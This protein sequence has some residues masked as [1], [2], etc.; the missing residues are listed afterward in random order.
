[1][2]P[3]R[4][5]VCLSCLRLCRHHTVC[6][7][8]LVRCQCNTNSKFLKLMHKEEIFTGDDKTCILAVVLIRIF[9]IIH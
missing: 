2:L 3:P 7:C 5:K 8:V 1:M 6:D 9:S 4:K